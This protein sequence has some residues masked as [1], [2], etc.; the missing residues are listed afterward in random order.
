MSD[1]GWSLTECSSFIIMDEQ[2]LTSALTHD[3]HFVK[4]GFQAF[5]R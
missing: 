2:Q 1:E 3:Q 4:A 5:L